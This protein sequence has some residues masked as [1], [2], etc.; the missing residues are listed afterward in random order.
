MTTSIFILTGAGISAE[1]GI[2]TFR[3]EDGLWANHR[4]EDVATPA[5]FKRNPDLV[6]NFY[7]ERRAGLASVVPNAAHDALARLQRLHKGTVTL[8]TQNIDDL[9]ERAGAQV[10]HMHGELVKARCVDCGTVQHW[11]DDITVESSCI[12]CNTQNT[13]RPHI[14]W[15]DEIPLHMNEIEK[16]LME[17]DTFAAIGTSGQVYPAAG[18]A[19]VANA[20]GAKT[21]ELNLKPSGSDRFCQSLVGPATETVPAWV[22]S[23]LDKGGCA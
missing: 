22:D 5:A 13:L 8:V 18:Y 14:V 11:T 6:Q 1:S 9:H 20:I 23:I 4:V 15:F 21:I 16:A 10:I 7:N 17:A 3:D 19:D 2:S 12:P